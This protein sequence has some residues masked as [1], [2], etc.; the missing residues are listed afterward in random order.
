[1]FLFFLFQQFPAAISILGSALIPAE[2]RGGR[3]ED[4]RDDMK[5]PLRRSP[6]FI[7][8]P[9]PLDSH[10]WDSFFLLLVLFL[11]SF[12]GVKNQLPQP[13]PGSQDDAG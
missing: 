12:P 1:M 8:T 9:L 10:V 11:V 2:R 13:T 3:R 4:A 7:F 6:G 5:K